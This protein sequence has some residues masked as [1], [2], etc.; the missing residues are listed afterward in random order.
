MD[1]MELLVYCCLFV[2]GIILFPV[3]IQGVA[4][5][6]MSLWTFAGH[7]GVSAFLGVFPYIYLTGIIVG[8]LYMVLRSKK[9]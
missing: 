8:P 4:A 6:D 5:V 7:E 2:F 9:K 1:Q 3:M